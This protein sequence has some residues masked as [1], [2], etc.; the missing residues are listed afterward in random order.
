MVARVDDLH[1]GDP[2][3]RRQH[4]AGRSC[5]PGP[6]RRRRVAVL[7]RGLVEHPDKGVAL[8]HD[9]QHGAGGDGEGEQRGRERVSRRRSDWR[10]H[11]RAGHVR[12]R[13]QLLSV[14]C[15]APAVSR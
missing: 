1:G 13:H 5:R 14:A 9:D 3:A 11:S 2:A 6:D 15:A 8:Q 12:Q 7:P 10:A 4:R